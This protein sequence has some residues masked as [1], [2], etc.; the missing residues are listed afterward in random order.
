MALKEQQVIFDGVAYVHGTG[1]GALLATDQELSFWG[2]VNAQTSEVIDRFHPLSGRLLDGAIIAIPGGRGSCS[3]S[4]T[5]LELILNGLA[6]KALVLERR[7]EI[8]TLGVMIAEE[9]F[10]RTVPV[11]VLKP[12]NFRQLVSWN[13]C[14]VYVHGGRISDAPLES[15]DNVDGGII[16]TSKVQLSARDQ[17]LLEGTHGQAARTAMKIILRIAEMVG[18]PELTDISQAHVDGAYFGPGSVTFGQRLRDW[19]GKFSVPTTIN[20]L[21]IDLQRWRALGVDPQYGMLCDELTNCYLEMGARTSF[22]CAPYLLESAP[23]AGA[24]VAWGE[25]NAVAYANSVLG[26]RSAKHANMLECL[27]GLTGRAPKAG[28]YLEENRRASLWIDVHL[29]GDVD[30]SCWPLLGYSIGTAASH[31]IPVVT[32]L[33]HLH[34]STDDLKAFGAAFGTSSSAPMFHIVNITPEARTLEAIYKRT[35]S[36]QPVNVGLQELLAC[37]NEFNHHNSSPLQVDLISLGNP[38]FSCKEIRKL[39]ELCRGRTKHASMAIMVTCGRSQHLLAQQAGCVDELE[40]F[41]VRFLTDTCWC[42]IEEPVLPHAVKVIMTN[43][44]KYAHYGPGLTGRRFRF[45]SL[46]QCVDTACERLSS[47]N[48]PVWL[49]RP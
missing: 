40:R 23:K 31:R 9:M 27:I 7:D 41:G 15:F 44:G 19:G 8:L 4:A 12:D 26:A 42:F 21:T 13:G 2:G 47:P 22:T 49:Q 16:S 46:M 32:G 17:A 38:H 11:V 24:A 10:G 30:D 36:S 28:L 34:P 3:G 35:A 39:A 20:A 6:P 1:L 14:T 48:P 25:S 45:G 18:A 5:I 29:P 43:S 37:W 33:D